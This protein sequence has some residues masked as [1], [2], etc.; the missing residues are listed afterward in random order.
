[1]F[2][3]EPEPPSKLSASMMRVMGSLQGTQRKTEREENNQQ[4][5]LNTS[6]VVK[7]ELLHTSQSN[8]LGPHLRQGDEVAAAAPPP[9]CPLERQFSEPKLV[10][11]SCLN[12]K[13]TVT[14]GDE[15]SFCSC[16]KEKNG[17][18]P[19]GTHK[20]PSRVIVRLGGLS[21]LRE[22]LINLGKLV[23][24]SRTNCEN[25]TPQVPVSHTGPHWVR[26]C[27]LALRFS[28]KI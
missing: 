21:G 4:L 12:Q 18:I 10:F 22:L 8:A 20:D 23:I 24:F 11:S 17:R 5:Q 6:S 25:S 2:A 27:F 3:A 15:K 7:G 19:T 28:L 9:C 1:M 16:N 13:L 14:L 26:F